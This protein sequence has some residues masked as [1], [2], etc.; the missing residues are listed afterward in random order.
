MAS[1]RER[2]PRRPGPAPAPQYTRYRARRRLFPRRSEEETLPA[3][4]RS[5][6]GRRRRWPGARRV[7]RWLVTAVMGW[8]LLSVLIFFVSAEIQRGKVAD[9]ARRVLDDGG[10]PL[11]SATNILVLGSDLRTEATAEPGA[12]TSGPSRSDS[13]LLMRVGAGHSARLSIPRDTV[14]D[15]PGRG[16]D[17]INAAYAH[18]GAALAI[19]TVQQFLGIEVNHV[20]EVSFDNFP[21]LVDALGGVDYAGGCVVSRIN[22]GFRNG[23][24]TLRL[25]RG[26]TRLD[27]KQAL[28]LARTRRNDCNPREDDFTRARR[29]QKLVA[30]INDRLLSP[31]TFVR[32]PWVA[33]AAPKAL[34]SD[35]GGVS[36][37]GVFAAMET[38]GA[39][40]P[41][42]LRPSG[43]VT[44]A[45]GSA[46][47]VVAE[48]E[49]AA[50]VRR[51]L[52][53]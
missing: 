24:Y 38:G 42:V 18:G 28:A 23:G 43:G 2:K 48:A 26:T 25:R 21:D 6:P 41:R 40:A 8:I 22:G 35:M 46:G 12:S 14:V 29:Q 1:P 27:G 31:T 4:T 44:L 32:L 16:R 36:L 9:D 52:R 11:T 47:L 49:K 45:N 10:F 19:Q 5:G 51:F 39:S 3:I 17:K 7:L 34:R 53:D 15:I 20:V 30:A 33:W 50:E 13:I 37:L